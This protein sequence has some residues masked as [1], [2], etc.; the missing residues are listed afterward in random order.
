MP[1]LITTAFCKEARGDCKEALALYASIISDSA[2]SLGASNVI[3]RTSVLLAYV[4]RFD[5]V[6]QRQIANCT[7]HEKNKKAVENVVGAFT[8]VA[9]FA[10]APIR[11]AA[12]FH[13]L[14]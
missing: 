8:T 14:T 12:V 3:F 7:K 1:P 9:P 6:R 2:L 5:E 11:L 13:V 4:G 10:G